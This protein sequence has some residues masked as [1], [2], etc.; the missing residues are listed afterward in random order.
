MLALA[1]QVATGQESCGIEAGRETRYMYV[2]RK[3]HDPIR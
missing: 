2:L 3:E 1:D